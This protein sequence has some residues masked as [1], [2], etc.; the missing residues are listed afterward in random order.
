M[1]DQNI[2][3]LDPSVFDDIFDEVDWDSDG[4]YNEEDIQ[5][6]RDAVDM[7]F[8]SA[9]E[10]QS[11][12][13]NPLNVANIRSFGVP[14]SQPPNTVYLDDIVSFSAPGQQL[15]SIP[16]FHSANPTNPSLHFPRTPG[17]PLG[18]D[19]LRPPISSTSA[20]YGGLILLATLIVREQ[21][22]FTN[23]EEAWLQ[24]VDKIISSGITDSRPLITTQ[25]NVNFGHLI[26]FYDLIHGDLQLVDEFASNVL[27][28]DSFRPIQ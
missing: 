22:T 25:W 17:N 9:M 14:A 24:V 8:F 15:P 2:L 6:W 20:T 4:F 12:Q 23:I 26:N 18:D 1:D 19:N 21:A 16:N 10:N 27:I 13:P 5:H 11:I 7:Q 28:S 3:D